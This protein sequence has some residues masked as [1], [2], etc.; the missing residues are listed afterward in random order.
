MKSIAEQELK[1]RQTLRENAI[2]LWFGQFVFFFFFFFV[3]AITM[4]QIA[5][6]L[7]IVKSILMNVKVG[8]LVR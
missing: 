4:A 2:Q 5:A 1:R 6:F 3:K 8:Q 7:F